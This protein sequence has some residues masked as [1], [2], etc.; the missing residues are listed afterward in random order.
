MINVTEAKALVKEN[1]LALNPVKIH[2][3]LAAS[4]ILAEDVFAICDIPAFRQSSMDGYAIKFADKDLTLKLSGEMAAGTEANF[5]IL[6]G[7]TAR[8]F[9]GAPLPDGADTVVMQE[10]IATVNDEVSVLDEKLKLGA[11]VRAKGSEV[12]TNALAMQKGNLLT[13]A[14]IGFLAGIGITEVS[15]YPMPKV[16]IIVTGKE[17]QQPGNKLNFGQVYES[18]SF[19]LKAAL[20]I[21]GIENVHVFQADDELDIL[22]N[23]LD[24]AMQISDVVLLTGGV[25]VG[26]YDFV[27]EATHL[28]E[29]DEI[30]HKVKQKPGKPLYFGKKNQQLVFGLPGNPSSVLNCFYNYVL[31]AIYSLSNK[32]NAVKEIKAKLAAAY[33]KPAGLT[34]FLKGFYED[35][36]AT[37]LNAQESYRLSSFAQANCLIVL[38]ETQENFQEG[39]IVN[40]LLLP[41]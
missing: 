38:T 37:P 23:I 24:E 20:K 28:C 11:N 13:P 10:K 14:A 25:S 31:P 26:D 9:T 17:L 7:E 32:V 22:K 21:A 27:I 3:S 8:I 36:F 19:S 41:E 15:V 6:N 16:S 5:T 29:V 4:H 40:V 33:Q 18:N 1:A 39:E 35:G 12:K 2:L 34:Q 30:F